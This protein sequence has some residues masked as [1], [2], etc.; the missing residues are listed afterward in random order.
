MCVALSMEFHKGIH[1][2]TKTWTTTESCT[3][4][5]S[6]S[7]WGSAA[8][9]VHKC[10]TEPHRHC[11]ACSCKCMWY[12]CSTKVQCTCMQSTAVMIIYTTQTLTHMFKEWANEVSSLLVI[13]CVDN[14]LVPYNGKVSV[15]K[16]DYGT[17]FLPPHEIKIVHVS[18]LYAY[19]QQ[20]QSHAY[21]FGW[22]SYYNMQ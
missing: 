9:I 19:N 2:W 15:I 3:Q 6:L 1:R 22:W 21:G 16:H 17:S 7:L 11:H 4:P 18:S 14:Q 12:T 20:Y 10:F 5:L 13:I 8:M